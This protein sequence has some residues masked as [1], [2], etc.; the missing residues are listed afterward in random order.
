MF[1]D[2]LVKEIEIMLIRQKDTGAEELQLK[3]KLYRN[4]KRSNMTKSA[5]ENRKKHS[6][7]PSQLVQ[8]VTGRS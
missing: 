1:R 4:D 8:S 2:Q 3:E 7:T 5:R 6:V